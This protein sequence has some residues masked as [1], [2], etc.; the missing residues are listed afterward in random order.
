MEVYTSDQLVANKILYKVSCN[1][2]TIKGER[3]F[4]VEKNPYIKFNS[5]Q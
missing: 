4:N 2:V 1:V 5:K 3:V